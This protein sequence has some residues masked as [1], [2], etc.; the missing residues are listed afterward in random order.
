MDLLG[1]YSDS[2]ADDQQTTADPTPGPA[3]QPTCR[4]VP[5]TAQP[6]PQPQRRN[7]APDDDGA[8]AGHHLQTAP[9]PATL[10]NP[11]ASP[12]A[13]RQTSNSSASP[14][15]GGGG[16]KRGFTQVTG[17]GPIQDA[18]PKASRN[19]ANPSGPKPAFT[20]ALVPP[21]LRNGRANVATEDVERIFSKGTLAK[22][23]PA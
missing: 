4:G 23:R 2:D 17:S 22:R 12:D 19:A 13:D 15:S 16:G 14:L 21:Q 10:F 6:Q 9:P 1:Q 8:G 20:T 7:A 3:G 5:A 18:P 11:F